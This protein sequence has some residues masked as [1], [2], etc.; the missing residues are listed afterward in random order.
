MAG[1]QYTWGTGRRKTSVARVRICDGS[2]EIRVNGKEYKTFF[3]TIDMQALVQQ[4]LQATET[5]SKFDVYVNVKGGGPI[6]QAGAVRLGIARAL[7]SVDATLEPALREAG[8]LTRDARMKERKKYGQRG[9]RR[10]FQFSK[11]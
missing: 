10:K 3:P 9:A 7:K 11:R 6:G 2:G 5:G 8:Y 1:K 4:P